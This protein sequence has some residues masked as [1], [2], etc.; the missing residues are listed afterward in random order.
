MKCLCGI[1]A[2]ME[3]AWIVSKDDEVEAVLESADLQVRPPSQQV[4]PA[5]EGSALGDVYAR[6][7]RMNEG[8]RH[9]ALR[10]RV[11]QVIA[12]WDMY[13]V[14][15]LAR[16]AAKRMPASEVAP[17]VVA[18]MIA[19]ES[20]EEALPWIRDFAGAIAGD[21]SDEAIARGVAATPN[22]LELLP[23]DD[24]PD[25][26]ANLLGFL[27]QTY[28][29]TGALIGNW[30]HG[31]SAPPVVMTRRWA[32]RDLEICGVRLKKGDAVVVLL[33]SHRFHF[34]AGRHRCPGQQIAEAIA[35]AT[36]ATLRHSS[37]GV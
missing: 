12:N 23:K 13:S 25:E 2:E 18:R 3:Y 19:F 16:D 10:P 26:V 32:A 27:F 8:R 31:Y 14:A 4:P 22:L 20:P 7:V 24:D 9:S 11:E 15:A 5:M 35:E 34:G 37:P 29:A 17:Y 30:M 36:V 21:A 28:A 33:T 6:L 1:L